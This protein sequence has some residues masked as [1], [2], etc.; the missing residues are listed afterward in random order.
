MSQASLTGSRPAVDSPAQ[1]GH[2]RN[3]ARTIF[4]YVVLAPMLLWFAIFTLYPVIFSFWTSLHLWTAEIG[5]ASPWAGAG[6]YISLLTTDP[7]FK[8]AFVNT[9]RYGFAVTLVVVPAGYLL[10]YCLRQVKFF[11]NGYTF[12]YFLPYLMPA[13]IIG[14]L[15]GFFYQPVFGTVNFVLGQLG[16]G[17]PGW[18]QD[19]RLALWTVASVEMWL[20]LG[21]A[22]LITFSGLVALPNSL[23]EAARIDGA[24]NWTL[25]TTIITPLMSRVLVFVSAVTMITALQTFD[26]IYVMTRTGGGTGGSAGGPGISTYTMAFL[27]YTEGLQRFQIGPATAVS[28]I[29]LVMVLAFTI[30]QLRFFRPDWEYYQD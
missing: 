29:L 12:I 11:N 26:L 7:F 17:R 20:R 30:L 25:F 3:P 22:T 28:S 5:F 24:N 13:A 4:P 2:R 14:I 21:F 1:R 15:F 10:A 6:N 9:L 19:P 23:I 27:V 8:T 18:L 16:L